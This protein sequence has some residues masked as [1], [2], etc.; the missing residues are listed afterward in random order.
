MS[1]IQLG[2]RVKDSITGFTGIVTVVSYWLNGCIR[3]GVQPE[4]MKDGKPG[5]AQHFDAVQL[6]IVEHA[7]HRPVVMT[8]E[9][10]PAPVARESTGGPARESASFGRF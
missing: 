6:R 9:E 5:E 10:A 2:D 1:T 7:V 8:P 4:E 3:V